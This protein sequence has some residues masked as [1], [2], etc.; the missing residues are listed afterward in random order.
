[1]TAQDISE[2]VKCEGETVVVNF[3]GAL[4]ST[5]IALHVGMGIEIL[6]FITGKRAR[7]TVVYVDPEQPRLC[8]I[9][10]DQPQNIW[11][12]SLPPEDWADDDGS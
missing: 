10:L 6:V 9:A 11:G 5:A 4:I 1:V 7:A 12:L 8:G 2:V 3:H